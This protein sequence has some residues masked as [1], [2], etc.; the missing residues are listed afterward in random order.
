MLKSTNMALI[1]IDV[2]EEYLNEASFIIAQC[3]GLH[4]INIQK[5]APGKIENR[6]TEQK[7]LVNRYQQLGDKLKSTLKHLSID[8]KESLEQE[9]QNDLYLKTDPEMGITSLENIA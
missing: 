5:V 8:Q 9:K 3:R 4:L 1:D 7:T 2:P 6:D